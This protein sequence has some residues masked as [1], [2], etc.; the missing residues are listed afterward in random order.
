MKLSFLALLL[1]FLPP[2]NHQMHQQYIVYTWISF[3]NW[4]RAKISEFSILLEL[5]KL[6]QHLGMIMALK[7]WFILVSVIFNTFSHILANFNLLANSSRNKKFI[8]RHNVPMF[9][10]EW[11]TTRLPTTMNALNNRC[12]WLVSVCPVKSRQMSLEV[13]QK[14]FH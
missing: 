1:C 13:A 4:K 11:D 12:L 9:R 14:W 3:V 6:Q 5:Q 7:T 10:V 2:N 8:P